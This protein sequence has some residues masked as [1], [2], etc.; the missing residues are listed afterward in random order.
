MLD[1][2]TRGCFLS[3]MSA[4]RVRT[5]SPEVHRC[6]LCGRHLVPR[7]RGDVAFNVYECRAC[8]VGLTWPPPG[9]ANGEEVFADDDEHYERQFEQRRDLWRSF[10]EALLDQIPPPHCRGRLLDV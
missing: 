5:S 7:W 10:G 2:I 4:E 3:K 1:T 9:E 8:G 6:S